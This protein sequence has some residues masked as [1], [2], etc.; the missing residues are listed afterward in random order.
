MLRIEVIDQLDRRLR[1]HAVASGEHRRQ[2]RGRDCRGLQVGQRAGKAV[3]A[4]PVGD[5]GL[6][7]RV[8]VVDRDRGGD[9]KRG[10]RRVQIVRFRFP[11]GGT[12]RLQRA[13]AL[14]VRVRAAHQA[15]FRQRLAAVGKERRRGG[16]GVER[17]LGQRGGPRGAVLQQVGRGGVVVQRAA[18]SRHRCRAALHHDAGI[19]RHVQHGLAHRHA[20]DQPAGI[21]LGRRHRGTAAIGHAGGDHHDPVL[22]QGALAGAVGRH[23]AEAVIDRPD[24]KFHR[25]Q[26]EL[27]PV[28]LRVALRMRMLER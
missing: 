19:G 6:R 14:F 15:L 8:G 24:R 11:A 20:V 28:L 27:A 5:A 12:Q 2:R 13:G 21:L 4:Q 17:R 23:G 10:Q 3:A 18:R 1:R 7:I 9:V 22:A 26:R 25:L 16:V